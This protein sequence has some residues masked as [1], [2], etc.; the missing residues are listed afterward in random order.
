[1]TDTL[2]SQARNDH[3][4]PDEVLQLID[5]MAG[6]NPIVVGG[7]SVNIWA[8]HYSQVDPDL[9]KFGPLTSKDVD[10]FANSKAVEQLAS[11]LAD[12]RVQLPQMGDASP[13]SAVVIGKLGKRKI[14]VDFLATILGVPGDSVTKNFVAIEGTMPG[15]NRQI[16]LCLMHPLDCVKSR[17]AN[18][19]LLSRHD[20]HSL[21]QAAA[22]LRVLGNFIDELLSEGVTKEAQRSLHELTYV[23]RDLHVGQ[24]SH[25]MFG[26]NFNFAA[27]FDRFSADE[28]LDNRWRN[29]YFRKA[30][31]RQY[32]R[33]ARFEKTSGKSRKGGIGD[34]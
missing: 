33:A 7:Q 5:F 31:A 28:R 9:M 16:T 24:K 32:A 11:N 12:S 15:T 22:S 29:L 2:K 6:S 17:L 18:T 1:M 30:V 34:D 23:Y 8:S 14:L 10:F 19:N 21:S 27:I 4:T 26:R 20:A 13:N 25:I 3:L